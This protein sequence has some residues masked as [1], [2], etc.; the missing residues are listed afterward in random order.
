MNPNEITHAATFS[1]NTVFWRT[2]I[3]LYLRVIVVLSD[4]CAAQELS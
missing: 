1:T 2:V 4:Q 3:S